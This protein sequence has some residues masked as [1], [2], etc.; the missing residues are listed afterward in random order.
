VTFL[1]NWFFEFKLKNNLLFKNKFK[2]I[3]L[4]IR[5][6]PLNDCGY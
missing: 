4:K 2:N 6:S 3:K 5:L 1:D